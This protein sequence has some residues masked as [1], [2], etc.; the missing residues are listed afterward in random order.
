MSINASLFIP[1]SGPFGLR[2]LSLA[3][4]TRHFPAPAK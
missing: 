2:R 4:A 3:L 1:P